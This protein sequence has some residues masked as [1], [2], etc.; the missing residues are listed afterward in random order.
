MGGGPPQYV[1]KYKLRS[2]LAIFEANVEK[3]LMVDSEWVQFLL[4]AFL[5]D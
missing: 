2:K 5:P 3:M 4:G 1:K